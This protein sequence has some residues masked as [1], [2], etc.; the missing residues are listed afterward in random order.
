MEIGQ[1]LLINWDKLQ[2]ILLVD[3]RIRYDHLHV[4]HFR[5]TDLTIIFKHF[6]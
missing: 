2:Y 6:A 1:I 4:S 5:D 3:S